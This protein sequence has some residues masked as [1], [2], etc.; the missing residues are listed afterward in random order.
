MSKCPNC[1]EPFDTQREKSF[2]CGT[3][4]AWFS[5][6]DKVWYVVPAPPNLQ[7][8]SPIGEGALRIPGDRQARAMSHP[9]TVA[10]NEDC[11]AGG[12][13]DPGGLAAGSGNADSEHVTEYLGGL[14]TVTQTADDEREGSGN[15]ENAEENTD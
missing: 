13:R 7:D 1:S 2:H 11:H 10:E 5:E 8:A 12:L 15:G 9:E 3:C 14:V 4:D 6:I